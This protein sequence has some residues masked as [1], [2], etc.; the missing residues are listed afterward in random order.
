M[1]AI[2]GKSS[3]VSSEE[4]QETHLFLL[5][6]AKQ[7]QEFSI[8]PVPVSTHPETEKPTDVP[9]PVV[10][11]PCDCKHYEDWWR[12]TCWKCASPYFR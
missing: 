3:P 12:R 11:D 1:F 8:K 4:Q 6:C 2:D 10:D 7:V 9:D 5:L